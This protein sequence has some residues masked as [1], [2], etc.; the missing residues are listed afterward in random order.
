MCWDLPNIFTA[1]GKN[2]TQQLDQ[3]MS[4]P[5]SKFF[6]GVGKVHNFE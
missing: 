1:Q 6:I 4:G 5:F 2:A 3:A